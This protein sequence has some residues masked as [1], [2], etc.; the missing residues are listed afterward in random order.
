MNIKGVSPI[1]FLSPETKVNEMIVKIAN[2]LLGLNDTNES[3]KT[4][5]LEK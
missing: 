4:R 5:G 2:N 3:F 1:L